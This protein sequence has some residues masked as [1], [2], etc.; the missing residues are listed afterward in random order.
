MEISDKLKEI[1]QTLKDSFYISTTVKEYDQYNNKI[2]F[3]GG[4]IG[5]TLLA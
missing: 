5:A 2:G 3:S 1:L 4:S